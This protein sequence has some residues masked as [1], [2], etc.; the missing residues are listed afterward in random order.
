MACNLPAKYNSQITREIA[1]NLT[2]KLG[3]N[4]HCIPI[5]EMVNVNNRL[6]ESFNPGELNRENIQAKIRGTS[7]LSNIAG[8][9][10]GVMTCN[11]NKVEIALG[12]TTLYGDVNGAIAPLGDLLKT[13][14][15]RWPHF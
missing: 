1:A 6:L 2:G 5:E 4:M 9:L 11:G 3:L 12:Y 15:L 7:I 14:V 10:N 13:E 8:I